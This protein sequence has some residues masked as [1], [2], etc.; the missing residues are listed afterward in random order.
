MVM[1]RGQ[2]Q[3]GPLAAAATGGLDGRGSGCGWRSG[4][5]GY[6]GQNYN[7]VQQQQQVGGQQQQQQHYEGHAPVQQHDS[8]Q[9][10]GSQQEQQQYGGGQL[11]V[12]A[13]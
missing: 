7:G 6:V 12:D 4:V 11:Y 1:E 13:Q 5:G 3:Q 10:L 9:K 2:Q 8:Q